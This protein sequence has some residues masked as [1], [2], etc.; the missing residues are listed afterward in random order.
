ME[1]VGERTVLGAPHSTPRELQDQA[2]GVGCSAYQAGF[3]DVPSFRRCR[4]P[5]RTRSGG[6]Q[7]RGGGREGGRDL[8][9]LDVEVGEEKMP[10]ERKW[11]LVEP[12]KRARPSGGSIDHT[13]SGRGRNRGT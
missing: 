13:P 9:V 12:S 8:V 3:L 2:S 5:W 11:V 1:A 10:E 6:C 4:R 7:G